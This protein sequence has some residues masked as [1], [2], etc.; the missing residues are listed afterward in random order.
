MQPF[1]SELARVEEWLVR[2]TTEPSGVLA[3]IRRAAELGTGVNDVTDLERLVTPG[4]R[5][6]ALERLAIYSD[7]YFARLVECLLDDYPALAQLLGAAQFERVARAYVAAEPSLSPSLNAY[8]RGMP[9]FLRTRSE[10]WAPFAAE[11]ARLEWALVEVIHAETTPPLEP[12][13]LQ[14]LRPEDWAH[15]RLVPSPALRVLCLSHPVNRFYSAFR[16]GN[17]PDL[18]ASAPTAVAVHRTGL[19]LYRLDL[20]PPMAILLAELAA[21][22]PLGA[23]IERLERTL[24]PE[25]L[26]TLPERLPEWFGAWIGAGFFTS[27]ELLDPH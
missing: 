16:E 6:S 3:G 15:A 19:S 5:L 25:V 10:A 9:E 22:T 7:G 17:R 12:Q 13:A 27:L 4:P 2:V 18:P 8:G 26:A 1:A 14:R 24:L 21:G 20:E 23:A 11:L